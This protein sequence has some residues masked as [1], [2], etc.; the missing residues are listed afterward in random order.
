[1]DAEA[2]TRWLL[3]RNPSALSEDLRAA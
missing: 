3:E 1:M 2:T